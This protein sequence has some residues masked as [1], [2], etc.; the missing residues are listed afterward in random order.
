MQLFHVLEELQGRQQ[1]SSDRTAAAKMLSRWTSQG[2]LRRVG[3]GAYVPVALDSLSSQ[4]VL[5][6]AWVLVPSLFAPAYVGGRT[7]SEYWDLSEQIFN[8][9]VVITTQTVRHK[10]QPRHGVTFTVKHVAEKKFFGTKTVWRGRSKVLVSDLERTVIDMLDDS[11][12]GGGIQHTS[13]CLAEYLRRKDRDDERLLDYMSRLG[14]GAVWKRLGFLAEQDASATHLVK[15]CHARLTKG[16]IKL[17][18]A[19]DCP[20]LVTRWR[21]WIPEHWKTRARRRRI[22]GEIP[23][24]RRRIT[25]LLDAVGGSHRRST[26]RDRLANSAPASLASTGEVREIFARVKESSYWEIPHKAQGKCPKAHRMPAPRRGGQ[27]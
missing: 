11:A 17:D 14:N 27:Y 10:S 4:H 3:R 26:P 5:D 13:D 19:L 16:N 20:Q 25:P 7:A 18:P 1:S 24:N 9:I 22:P 12:I 8:D 21:L 6:D 2:W 15:A 23:S